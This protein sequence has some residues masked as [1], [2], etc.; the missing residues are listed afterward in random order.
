MKK[1][2]LSLVL[3]LSASTFA[4][5]KPLWSLVNSEC[6]ENTSVTLDMNLPD[7]A[8]FSSVTG[9]ESLLQVV[10]LSYDKNTT[11]YF[12]ITD[13]VRRMGATTMTL[14]EVSVTRDGRYTFLNDLKDGGEVMEVVTRFGVAGRTLS[15][16]G[17]NIN[18]YVVYNTESL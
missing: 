5:V 4:E 18:M 2:L 17:F 12:L 1:L 6:G 10:E 7:R 11:K 16:P 8:C 14:E 3:L 15:G 9:E 13:Q